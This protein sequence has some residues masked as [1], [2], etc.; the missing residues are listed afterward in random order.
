M[1]TS[2]I[3]KDLEDAEKQ[4]NSSLN[5]FEGDTDKIHIGNYQIGDYFHLYTRENQDD[6]YFQPVCMI[7]SS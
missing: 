3:L 4:D 2:Q 1:D 6:A 7:F 5:I